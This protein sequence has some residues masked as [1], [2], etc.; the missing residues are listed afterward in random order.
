MPDEVES[1][2]NTQQA[3]SDLATTLISRSRREEDIIL[4]LI[5]NKPWYLQIWAILELKM[6]RDIVDP[7]E[8]KENIKANLSTVAI[9]GALFGGTNTASFMAADGVNEEKQT[10]I[11]QFI[12]AL[13]VLAAALGFGAAVYSAVIMTMT[14]SIPKVIIFILYRQ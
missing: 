6:V 3:S 2:W 9:I 10:Q 4:E 8:L 12:G 14:N 13:R 11:G 5:E 1:P 7:A